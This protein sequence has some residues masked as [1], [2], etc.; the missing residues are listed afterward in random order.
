VL[1]VDT[2]QWVLNIDNDKL[3]ILDIVINSYYVLITN[4][5]KIN[6]YNDGLWSI[7]IKKKTCDSKRR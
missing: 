7:E 3:L 1:T 5:T 2:K 6:I 4:C